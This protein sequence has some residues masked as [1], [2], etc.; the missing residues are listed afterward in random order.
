MLK[1][2]QKT[3]ISP[4]QEPEQEPEQE[5][6]QEQEPEQ[7]RE[8]EQEQEQE[9]EQERERKQEHKSE[10]LRAMLLL[11]PDPLNP[12]NI[13]QQTGG[14]PASSSSIDQSGGA[15]ADPAGPIDYIGSIGV[16]GKWSRGLGHECVPSDNLV[17]I[18]IRERERERE[19]GRER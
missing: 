11:D 12:V 8:H 13:C 4:R 1:R 19:G 16:G 9:Q 17:C 6:E 3:P 15:P 14:A 2:G 18:P 10:D 5:Q 7:K